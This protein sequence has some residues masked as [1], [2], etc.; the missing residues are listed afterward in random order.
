MVTCVKMGVFIT[1]QPYPQPKL[2]GPSAPQFLHPHL[3]LH[4]LTHTDMRHGVF[5][6]AAHIFWVLPTYAHIL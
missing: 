3:C 5:M 2:R 1:G 6:G 4:H